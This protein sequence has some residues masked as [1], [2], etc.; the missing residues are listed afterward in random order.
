LHFNTRKLIASSAMSA[1][2]IV[3]NI[4]VAMTSFGAIRISDAV[5]MKQ[6]R[7]GAGAAS[8]TRDKLNVRNS[9][10]G[11]NLEDL[12][13]G[14]APPRLDCGPEEM[15]CC[16]EFADSLRGISIDFQCD[17]A[18]WF[19]VIGCSKGEDSH[20]ADVRVSDLYVDSTNPVLD[21]GNCMFDSL[22][23]ALD[24]GKFDA[25][26]RDPEI[27]LAAS[28]LRV[29]AASLIAEDERNRQNFFQGLRRQGAWEGFKKR[30]AFNH[31]NDAA[32]IEWIVGDWANPPME[33]GKIAGGTV[34]YGDRGVL[35]LLATSIGV[36][37][38]VLDVN[39]HEDGGP[40]G[41]GHLVLYVRQ[42][43]QHYNA[44]KKVDQVRAEAVTSRADWCNRI[45]EEDPKPGGGPR[46][47][48]SNGGSCKCPKYHVLSENC[49]KG[50]NFGPGTRYY[51]KT[52]LA[53]FQDR[54]MANCKCVPDAR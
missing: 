36:R 45:I 53:G 37:V 30:F 5:R 50:N 33:H 41:S 6:S 54:D 8:D 15:F 28:Q 24:A 26:T 11:A 51:S 17:V 44:V 19:Y 39:Y 21:G 42:V 52:A 48:W 47:F 1:K 22:A 18:G 12:R 10:C 7:N 20:V 32:F 25:A 49:P 34:Y 27:A 13:N 16:S 40:V 43:G 9:P 14:V 23:R 38:Q 3:L 46:K 29:Q 4:M 35:G 31:W 2:C